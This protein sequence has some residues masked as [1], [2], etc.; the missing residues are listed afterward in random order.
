VAL[1][2]A[3]AQIVD[4][5]AYDKTHLAHQESAFEIVAPFMGENNYSCL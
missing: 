3:L 2:Y 1:H 4:R 5:R